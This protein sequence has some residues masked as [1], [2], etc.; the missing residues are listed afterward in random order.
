MK[1]VTSIGNIAFEG[2][3]GLTSINI[4]EE[5]TNIEF[6]AFGNCNNL[7]NVY[8]S[9]TK[10]EWNS[11]TMENGNESLQNARI[12]YNGVKPEPGKEITLSY[13]NGK[14]KLGDE[15]DVKNG[16]VLIE[17]K[18]ENGRFT[19][20]KSYNVTDDTDEIEVSGKTGN[21]Y[22]LWDSKGGMYQLADSV[23]VD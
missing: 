12:Y 14:I 16:A 23:T 10:E 3:S 4:S 18:Y 2:C 1:G 22:I 7:K 19:G 8:Y 21:R 20:M 15:Y 11:I 5:V 6:Y 13:D 9:G 17:A